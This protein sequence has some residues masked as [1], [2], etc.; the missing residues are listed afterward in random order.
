LLTLRGTPFLYYGEELGMGDVRVP[1]RE[2]VDPPARRY[3]PLPLWWNR[4]GSRSPLPWGPTRPARTWM[5][6]IPEVPTRN[7]ETQ[8]ADRDSVLATYR[9]LIWLRRAEPAL[10]VGGFEWVVRARDGVLAYRRTTPTQRILVAINLRPTRR[11]VDLHVG[12]AR[13]LLSTATGSPTGPTNGRL[14]L[15]PDEAVILREV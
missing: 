15:R 3:W 13:V 8:A 11:A 1:R 4:D 6:M 5:R 14:E 9:R 2:I 7:V 12:T 10:Q